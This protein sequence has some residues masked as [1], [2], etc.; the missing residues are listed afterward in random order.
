VDLRLFSPSQRQVVEAGE[1][2]LSVLAGP[3][4]G[5]TTVLA[6]RIGYLVETRG[7]PPAS[8]LAITFTTAAAATLRERLAGIVGEAAQELTITT[9]HALGLR[10]IKQWSQELG[11]GD[12]V[13]SVYG[14]DDAGAV[15]REIAT[16]F[17]LAVAPDSAVRNPDPWA[18]SLSKLM[19]ALD[20]FRLGV[21]DEHANSPVS[22]DLDDELLLSMTSAYEALLRRRGAVDYPFMLKLPLSLFEAEPRALRFVQDAYRFV[23]ADE[24]QDTCPTQ[25]KLLRDIVD[26]HHNLAVVGDPAQACFEWRGAQPGILLDFPLQYPEAQVFA[27]NQNYRSTGV[28]VALSNALAAPLETGRASFTG[29]ARGPQA[30]VYVASD[31]LDEARFV[32]GQVKALLASGQIDH[33][34]EVA[35]LFRT[36]AQARV[37]ALTLR[38]AGVPFRVRHDADLFAQPAVRDVVAYLRLAHSPSDGPALA[39]VLNVP[40]R[41]LRAVQQ[42][43]RRRPVPVSELPSWAQKR[44][45]PSARRAVEEVLAMLGDLHE[46]TRECSPLI[47][48]DTVLERTRYGS[49]LQMQDDAQAGLKQLEELRTVIEGSPA[50]DLATWL[51]DMHIGDVD[52][53]SPAAHQAVTLSTIHA[54]KGAEWPV[55]FVVGFEDGLLPHHQN[56][57]VKQGSATEDAERRLAYVAVSRTQVLLYLVY[58]QAR[59]IGGDAHAGRVEPRRASRFMANLP[60]DLLQPI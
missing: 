4:S 53:L 13:P 47:A 17:G 39:Q 56:S 24:F 44:G 49:W 16:Q 10:I 33:P 20:R 28:I 50:P 32:S 7:V 40:P 38:A 31:E 41:R 29:N 30:R 5:K 8:I 54:A 35:V 3:G 27:L 37:L 46:S 18:V 43:L 60:A 26:H 14:R 23:M 34:G 2:P 22:V 1:G 21:A 58:S 48:F 59:R 45:G 52:G 9:F 11:F 36:N 55:V 12:A 15:L 42:A 57:A 51:I 6:G 19:Y 25:F